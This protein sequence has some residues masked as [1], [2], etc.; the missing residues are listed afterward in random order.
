L[1]NNLKRKKEVINVCHI[2]SGDLWAGAEVMISNLLKILCK[3]RNLNIFVVILNDGR[4]CEE[5]RNSN[6]KVFVLDEKKAPF[7]TLSYKIYKIIKLIQPDIIHSHR[8]KENILSFF[9]KMIFNCRKIVTTQHG[10]P[11]YFGGKRSIHH[12]VVT[13]LNFFLMKHTFDR[14][15]CVSNDIKNRLSNLIGIKDEILT[16]IHNGIKIPAEGKA[17][18]PDGPFRIGTAG[19]LFP[20]KDYP[21]FIKIAYEILK[22]DQNVRFLLAGEGPDKPLLREL[23]DKYQI[24]KNFEFLGHVENM[25]T[26]YGELDLYLNTSVH[27]GIPMS[28]LEAMAHGVPVVAPKTGGLCEIVE[29]A[30]S[31]YLI[32]SRN[33]DE[34]A[35]V[36]LNIIKN[37]ELHRNLSIEAKK[38]V[39]T[40]FS[41]E[42][43]AECYYR[44]YRDLGTAS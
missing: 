41:A 39:G 33:P 17:L 44:L 14:L 29:D 16:V 2:I 7:I 24:F 22:K 8:Y 23:V 25:K 10:M 35:S 36:C 43:M 26:F 9:N 3:N 6:I 5:L 21:L 40:A 18:N 42:H 4:L 34:F 15:T 31:G 11:E 37:L 32:D 1:I 19:R 38:R 20:V 27:E 28:V 30:K 13:R 12:T